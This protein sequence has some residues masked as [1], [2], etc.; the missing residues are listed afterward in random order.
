MISADSPGECLAS[1]RISA[2]QAQ[3]LR[4]PRPKLTISEKKNPLFN[5]AVRRLPTD[6]TLVPW[7]DGRGAT[8]IP[9]FVNQSVFRDQNQQTSWP[10]YLCGCFSRH[11]TQLVSNIV[12]ISIVNGHQQ[13]HQT[14]TDLE[15]GGSDKLSPNNILDHIEIAVF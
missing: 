1:R 5:N 12:V 6:H 14:L 11:C 3:K 15:G 7:T 13:R 10:A 4:N 9:C 2:S 8:V